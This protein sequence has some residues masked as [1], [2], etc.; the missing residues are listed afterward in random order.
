MGFGARDLDRTPHIL[1]SALRRCRNVAPKIQ[2]STGYFSKCVEL[3]TPD[4]N[5]EPCAG[6]FT[7]GVTS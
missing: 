7:D 3:K 4:H 1:S 2:G 5:V 6:F